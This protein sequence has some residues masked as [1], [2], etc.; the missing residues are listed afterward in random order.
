[1]A[2]YKIVLVRHGESE[3]NKTNQFSGWY[4]ADLSELGLQEAKEAG[5]VSYFRA[6][7]RVTTGRQSTF[8]KTP[9]RLKSH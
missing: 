2:C 9:V 1:M 4:D 8:L 6:K 5:K 3:W 7:Y